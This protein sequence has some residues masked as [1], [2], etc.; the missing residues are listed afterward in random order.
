MANPSPNR[1]LF[2]A[3]MAFT[4]ACVAFL[5]A[6]SGVP[7]KLRMVPWVD[8]IASAGRFTNWLGLLVAAIAVF[9][10]CILLGYWAHLPPRTPKSATAASGS[11]Q[12]TEWVRG[13]VKAEWLT[14]TKWLLTIVLFG[15]ASF[16]YTELKEHFQKTEE[17]RVRRR[18]LA[19]STTEAISQFRA[20]LIEFGSDCLASLGRERLQAAAPN[21][22]ILSSECSANYA[23]VVDGWTRSTWLL[24][25]LIAELQ[26]DECSRRASD[27][28][29]G[30]LRQAACKR[31]G[32][33]GALGESSLE[34]RH[35]IQHYAALR[36][37][38]AAADLER[39][40]DSAE[41]L[42]STTRKVSCALLFIQSKH[43]PVP[44]CYCTNLFTSPGQELDASCKAP[45]AGMTADGTEMD[46]IRLNE[47]ERAQ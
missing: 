42:L 41:A 15:A 24:P 23:R 44:T 7:A 34:Y 3:G 46:P 14:I 38:R 22:V 1:I 37:S 43:L 35:L 39:L 10:S 9:A 4:A 2:A 29:S 18:E 13:I 31:L 6:V 20:A 5:A 19:R 33:V 16:A 8:A 27:E 40:R 36:H 26:A 17:E 21:E 47:F 32:G 45:A 28:T 25:L 12:F 11:R 30:A